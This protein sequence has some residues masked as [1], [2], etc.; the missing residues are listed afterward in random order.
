MTTTL[1]ILAVIQIALAII[2]AYLYIN[3]L[4]G[5]WWIFI[6]PIGA[7]LPFVILGANS[8]GINILPMSITLLTVHSFSI[9]CA[10]D[11]T[12]S[13][14]DEEWEVI[15]V[16][17]LIIMFAVWIIFG[18]IWVSDWVSKS[19]S[20][21]CTES[22]LAIT[23]FWFNFN[24]YPPVNKIY[25]NNWGIIIYFINYIYFSLILEYNSFI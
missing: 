22:R 19:F 8:C 5:M 7:F 23:C 11:Y 18:Y 21:Q 3:V 17:S 20:V 9:F 25:F 2:T 4:E 12:N 15:S 13:S 6:I 16:I 24:N 1:F 10:L 14:Y